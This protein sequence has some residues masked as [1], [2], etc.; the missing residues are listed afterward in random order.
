M[1]FDCV[2]IMMEGMGLK[3]LAERF[4]DPEVKRGYE[5]MFLMD[6]PRNTRFAINYV[7]SIGLGVIT[8]E[9]REIVIN[10]HHRLL[11]MVEIEVMVGYYRREDY[12]DREHLNQL[13]N[14]DKLR[15]CSLARS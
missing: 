10:L 2:K 7:M 9:M 5:G 15:L 14:N 4:K 3:A 6:V 11:V 12:R 1:V 13:W 8:E